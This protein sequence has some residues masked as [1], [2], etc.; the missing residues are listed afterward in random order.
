[1]R[2]PREKTL[3][4]LKDT[5]V[6]SLEDGQKGS[7]FPTLHMYL[8]ME[9]EDIDN[10]TVRRLREEFIRIREALPEL[11][12]GLFEKGEFVPIEYITSKTYPS[13]H[14]PWILQQTGMLQDHPAKNKLEEAIEQCIEMCDKA[15]R[16][17][18][19]FGKYTK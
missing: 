8:E 5:V 4:V 6:N 17:D 13:P 12:V 3:D 10:S 2:V 16:R 9:G 14:A 1:M 15:I 18:C 19:G 11:N 7:K